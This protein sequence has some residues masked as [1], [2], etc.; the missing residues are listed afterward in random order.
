MLVERDM[1]KWY[2]SFDTQVI[3]ALYTWKTQTLINFLE[4]YFMK[5]H[6]A[7]TMMKLQYSLF[8]CHD[9]ASFSA[10]TRETY[11]RHYDMVKSKVPKERL[12]VYELGSGWEP[13]C[14]FLGKPI[15]DEPF[16]FKN[17]SKEFEIWMRKIQTKVLL[18]GIR[19]AARFMVIPAG[20]ALAA[21]GLQK[22][23]WL[24]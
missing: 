21:W 6:P 14:K 19:E 13:L 5:A 24:A 11:R 17:E 23:G 22:S 16:P 9:Q 8:N 3:P 1:D 2:H 4:P 7:T 10:N 15:P 18:S 12:L 20:I